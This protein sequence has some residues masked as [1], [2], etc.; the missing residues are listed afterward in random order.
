MMDLIYF[1]RGYGDEIHA[2]EYQEDF[3]KEIKENFPDVRLEDSYDEI[4][5]YRQSVFIDD[6]KKDDYMAYLIGKGWID[7]SL[8]LQIAMMDKDE[9][10]DA[11]RWFKIAKEKYPEAFKPEK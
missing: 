8:T 5:G 1:G 10:K 11:K 2:K 6:E 4:K 7:F 9:Q 3:I